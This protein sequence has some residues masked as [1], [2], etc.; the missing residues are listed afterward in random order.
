[1]CGRVLYVQLS[2]PRG[3]VDLHSLLG[4]D[5]EVGVGSPDLRSSLWK[6]R[7]EFLKSALQLLV[8]CHVV[9]WVQEGSRLLSSLLEQLKI[10]QASLSPFGFRV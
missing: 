2:T 6:R 9:V 8:S 5:V 4:A 10:L 3:I 1:M 7:S